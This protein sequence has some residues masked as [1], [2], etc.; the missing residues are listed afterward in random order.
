MKMVNI[1]W[2]MDYN[3]FITYTILNFIY[4]E[5]WGAKLLEHG[6]PAVLHSGGMLPQEVYGNFRCSEVHSGSF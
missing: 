4:L 5:S 6:C 1:Y 3:A 2:D